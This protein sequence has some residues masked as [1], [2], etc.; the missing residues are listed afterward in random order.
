M[1]RV[2]VTGN[3][4]GGKLEILDKEGFRRE[5]ASTFKDDAIVDVIIEKQ[6]KNRSNRQNKYLWAV[7]YKLIADHTGYTDEEI[8][9][10]LKYKFLRKHF[11]VGDEQY[12]VGGTTTKLT[13]VEFEEYTE[14]IR[15]WGATLSINIPLPNENEA[16]LDMLNEQL[17][18]QKQS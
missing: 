7:C 2:A 6:S 5:V 17:D 4:K 12:D 9:E 15:R 18:L 13:T 10:I 16:K 11:T 8:H 1:N 14:K 3:I